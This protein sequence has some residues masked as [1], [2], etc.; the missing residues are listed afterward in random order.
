MP[1]EIVRLDYDVWYA[2]GKADGALEP[3]E[4]PQTNADG[5][6]F[7]VR[8]RTTTDGD[9]FWPDS[10]GFLSVEEAKRVAET[11]LPSLVMWE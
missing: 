7:Y 3:G 10:T 8:F 9:R 6:V 4:Q 5:H 2:L 1:V 11:R